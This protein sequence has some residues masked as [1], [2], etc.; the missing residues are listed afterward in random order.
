MLCI[1]SVWYGRRYGAFIGDVHRRGAF[2]GGFAK[3]TA[4]ALR[5]VWIK[6]RRPQKNGMWRIGAACMPI[7][8]AD[9][10]RGKPTRTA[11]LLLLKRY[12]MIPIMTL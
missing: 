3:L 9:G 8:K 4:D 6:M 5:A 12:R 7:I 1:L 10:I 11:L 2:L